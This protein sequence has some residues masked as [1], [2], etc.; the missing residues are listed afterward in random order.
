MTVEQKLA[1][2]LEQQTPEPPRPVTVEDLRPP[3]RGRVWL[4]VLAA[5]CVVLI[6]LVALAIANRT[7]SDHSAPAVTTSPSPVRTTSAAPSASPTRPGRTAPTLPSREWNAQAIAPIALTSTQLAAADGVVYGVGPGGIVAM[8]TSGRVL[9]S[10]PVPGELVP[11]AG[12]I[13]ADGAVWFATSTAHTMTV[14]GLAERTLDV[15]AEGTASDAT[16]VTTTTLT[17]APGGRLLLAGGHTIAWMNPATGVLEHR[18][19]L[20]G[21]TITGAAQ[22][23]A[24]GPVYVTTRPPHS[25]SSTLRTVDPD[26]GAVSGATSTPDDNAAVVAASAGGVWLA[27]GT[28][29]MFYLAFAPGGDLTRLKPMGFGA[30]GISA[31]VWIDGSTAWVGGEQLACVDTDSGRVRASTA[32][33]YHR[34]AAAIEGLVK[35]NGRM[36]AVYVGDPAGEYLVELHPPAACTR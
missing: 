27:Y 17:A 21:G 3:S 33:R 26:N 24:G 14:V 10:H 34:Y 28:G 2:W 7:T 19:H 13:L 30:G 32:V 23:V 11:S 25:T 18:L 35:V 15:R 5:A 36:Y 29:H 9:A 1:D 4:P 8:T 16:I 31:S 6:V 20:G 12:P 22:A